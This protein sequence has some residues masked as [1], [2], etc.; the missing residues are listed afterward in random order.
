MSDLFVAKASQNSLA[1][2]VALLERNV[3]I[4]HA[5]YISKY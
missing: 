5:C 2:D 3:A 4:M 1:R